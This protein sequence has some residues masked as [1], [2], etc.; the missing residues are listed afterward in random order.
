MLVSAKGY[1]RLAT[2]M[3]EAAAR[4]C[5]GRLV[6]EHEGGYSAELVPFCGLEIIERLSGIETEVRQTILQDYPA[7]MGQQELQPHQEA[8]IDQIAA[9]NS[10]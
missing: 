4:L 6:V 3:L 8:T 1:G 9:F 2:I 7:N 5:D 10:L